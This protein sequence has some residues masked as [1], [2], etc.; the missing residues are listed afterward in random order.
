MKDDIM[1]WI[2]SLTQV[3]APFFLVLSPIIS[4]ADQIVS[5]HRRK[6][7]AGF[8]LDIPLIMLVASFLRIF[9]WPHAQYDTSLL[10]QSMIMVLIQLM[11]LKV[12]LD[13][14]P[15]TPVKGE[16][17]V[18]HAGHDDTIFG[19][20]RPYD[21]WQWQS[22]RQYWQAI[23]YFAAGL[24]VLQLVLSQ[25]PALYALY[26]NTIG[27]IGLAVEATLPLPQ[28]LMN[29][30]T[31]SCKGLRLSLLASWV[32]GD[33]MKLVWFFTATSE[34]P[35]SFKVS[36]MF[37]ASCDWFLAAQYMMYSDSEQ[38][39]AIK[40]HPMTEWDSPPTKAREHSLS[41]TANRQKTFHDG[42]A[43]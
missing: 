23:S 22:P 12:A 5:M 27:Y 17:G 1:G 42:P 32:G 2:L 30:R 8:S 13:H 36:G 28:I 25:I 37:Q 38:P 7:S 29:I 14:R 3:V 40:E 15:P 34:I 20:K 4:Y 35:W 43:E 31:R 10:L 9:Y 6:S 11:L 21:F 19:F 24:V 33:C 26:S 41:F 18:P 39:A 16:A